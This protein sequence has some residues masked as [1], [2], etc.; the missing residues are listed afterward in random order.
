MREETGVLGGLYAKGAMT[1]SVLLH[2]PT[3]IITASSIRTAL[4]MATADALPL[5]L[6]NPH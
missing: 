5:W 4:V 1:G 6:E 2:L 3:S